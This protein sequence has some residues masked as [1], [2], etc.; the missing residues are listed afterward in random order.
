MQKTLNSYHQVPEAKIKYC[1]RSSLPQVYT[2]QS[3]KPRRRKKKNL[4]WNAKSERPLAVSLKVCQMNEMY[5][6]NLWRDH[7][8]L[9]LFIFLV[10]EN[11]YISFIFTLYILK[12]M[13]LYSTT[14]VN[15]S[16]GYWIPLFC[17]F[18][19]F[20]DHSFQFLRVPGP[21]FQRVPLGSLFSD[22]SRVTL[23][24]RFSSVFRVPIGSH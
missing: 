20:S 17:L 3:K 21:I 11:I 23:G 10:S 8:K 24:A 22:L 13:L 19:G 4:R 12:E 7:Q 2:K 14:S 1:S 9:K 18:L 15:V 5:F 16:L 6:W